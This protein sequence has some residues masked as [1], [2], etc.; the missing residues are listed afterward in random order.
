MSGRYAIR[1]GIQHGCYSAVVAT[2]LP[3]RERTIAEGFKDA[4]YDT[5]ALGKWHL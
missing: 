5:F 2:G 4:G 1:T 3:L